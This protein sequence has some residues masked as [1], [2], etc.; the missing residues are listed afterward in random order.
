MYLSMPECNFFLCRRTVLCYDIIM[1]K[2]LHPGMIT[3]SVKEILYK[4]VIYQADALL[5][6]K[7]IKRNCYKIY[8]RA[9]KTG[10]LVRPTV[11]QVC[12]IRPAAHGHHRSYLYPLDVTWL[13]EFHHAMIHSK[14]LS[15][16]IDI[17][18]G[19][20][21]AKRA[22]KLRKLMLPVGQRALSRKPVLP[23]NS[24]DYIPPCPYKWRIVTG[25]EDCG[26]GAAPSCID[27]FEVFGNSSAPDNR[28]NP[29]NF[30]SECDKAKAH[31]AE[32]ELNRHSYTP[33]TYR[34]LKEIYESKLR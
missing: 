21:G 16:N 26:R 8:G 33:T 11:C 19:L 25:K 34:R 9:L 20:I 32:I 17:I 22:E 14:S 1:I 2:K 18:A 15:N 29:V 30:V 28:T 5:L 27:K 24:P 23:E 7:I 31:L 3:T 10:T 4:P 13:C 6:L 12:G